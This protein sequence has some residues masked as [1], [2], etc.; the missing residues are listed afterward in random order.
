MSDKNN[1]LVIFLA[2][3]NDRDNTLRYLRCVASATMVPNDLCI[4]RIILV[5]TVMQGFS[6]PGNSNWILLGH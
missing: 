1:K 5:P 3:A 2:F 6:C 4:L